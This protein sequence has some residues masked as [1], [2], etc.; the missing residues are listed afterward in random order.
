MS[1]PFFSICIPVY[2]NIQFLERLLQSIRIQ[3][4]TDYEVVVSD[5]SPD[6]RVEKYLRENYADLPI[7]YY[8]N[9]KALGTPANWNF[10]IEKATG[11]WIKLM[12]DDDWF[13]SEE[14]LSIF[15]KAVE[16][17]KATFFYCNYSNVL[18][19]NVAMSSEKIDGSGWRKK[20]IDTSPEVLYAR[21]VIGPPSVTLVHHTVEA[22]YDTRMKWLVDIDFYISVLRTGKA[23]YIPELL[24]H[25]GLGDEQVT[26]Y[27][28]NKPEVEIP[29]GLLL[30]SKLG[31][32]A[33]NTWLYY[34]GWWRLMRNLKIRSLEALEVYAKDLPVSDILVQMLRHQGFFPAIWLQIGVLSKASMFMSWMMQLF[35]GRFK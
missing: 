25:V 35:A 26:Q 28:H 21:N 34:D 29:E 2:K 20:L 19:S 24:V 18:L 31:D 14:S 13:A 5:D 10:A 17:S 11:L 15:H 9:A 27:T 6:D 23:Q 3:T 7:T 22:A 8:R 4:F 16:G 30:H 33:F 32:T 1:Q 12:H